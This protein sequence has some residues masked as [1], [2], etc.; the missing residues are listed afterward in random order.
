MTTRSPDLEQPRVTATLVQDT[1]RRQTKQK[2]KD[3]S[4]HI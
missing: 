4:S 3:K 1:E 2:Q